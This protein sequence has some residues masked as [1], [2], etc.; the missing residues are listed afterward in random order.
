MRQKL[1]LCNSRERYFIASIYCIT[2]SSTMSCV[3]YK[4]SSH[5]WQLHAFIVW[6]HDLLSGFKYDKQCIL[7]HVFHRTSVLFIWRSSL[8]VLIGVWI[9]HII[10]YHIIGIPS[11]RIPM[12]KA[13]VAEKILMCCMNN[14][15]SFT[16]LKFISTVG[17][18]GLPI[19]VLTGCKCI[20]IY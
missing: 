11:H 16:L 5:K 8:N 15:I 13:E 19:L 6:W 7:L 1:C 12:D 2:R 17:H 14:I 4:Q 20:S 3:S 9:S 10:S 18:L